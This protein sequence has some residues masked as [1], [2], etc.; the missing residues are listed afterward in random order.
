MHANEVIEAFLGNMRTKIMMAHAEPGSN[1]YSAEL[2]GQHMAQRK[3]F[4]VG[5]GTQNMTSSATEFM[6]YL[7]EPYQFGLLKN[8]GKRN[9]YICEAYMLITALTFE[10]G[11]PYMKVAFDQRAG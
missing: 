6:K 11:L 5:A 1:K 9:G 8:G 7:V 3:G 10:G 4:N 2:I